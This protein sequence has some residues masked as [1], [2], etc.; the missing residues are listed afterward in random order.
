MWDRDGQRKLVSSFLVNI[1][2]GSVLVLN[3]H[4]EQF[5]SRQLCLKEPDEVFEGECK[6]LLDGQQ[7]VSTL[8]S[9]FVDLF[10]GDW[11]Q[12]LND[13]FPPLQNRWLLRIRPEQHEEVDPFGWRSLRFDR[14][15]LANLDPAEIEDFLVCKKIFVKDTEK[16]YNPQYEQVVLKG[17]APNER[18]LT[19]AK[20]AAPQAMVPLYR[21]WNRNGE[22]KPLHEYVLNRIAKERED[23]LRAQVEDGKLS[24]VEV[25]RPADPDIKEYLAD[26]DDDAINQTWMKLRTEWASG[27]QQY[28]ESLPQQPIAC[29]WLESDEVNRA[30]PI[31]E[32]LNRQGTP[33]SVF[34]L[35]VARAA[36]ADPT[37]ESLTTRLVGL[38]SEER[39]LPQSLRKIVPVPDRWSARE[40]GAVDR[41]GNIVSFTKNQ[42]LNLLS[43]FSY[44]KYGS[45]SRE[46]GVRT[47]ELNV[48]YIKRKQI[49]DS[50]AS[51]STITSV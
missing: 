1:P 28:L 32:N 6:Y 30:I 34:D 20:E 49:L 18:K 13:L 43:L 9:V 2:V 46:V 10:E 14:G 25:L 8:K 36:L 35:V 42:F 50:L 24:L 19:V 4:G 38:L 21:V 5:A 27:V 44:F 33:L 26:D 15:T 3:G 23:Q 31:F 45:F 22:K 7:R 41:E 11:Y 39:P 12:S 47:Y 48:D 40:A 29:I 51:R 17:A 37:G 16:W